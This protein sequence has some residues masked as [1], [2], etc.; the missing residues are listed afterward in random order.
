MKLGK[1]FRYEFRYQL[2]HAST[3][4]FLAVLLLLPVVL[5]KTSTPADGTYHNAPSSIAFFTVGAGVLWL[6]MAG[7][8][9]GDAAARDVQTRMHPLL[10]TAPVSKASYLG[11]RFLAALALNSLLLL[12]VQVGLL[13][14]FHTPGSR[15]GVLLGPFRPDAYLTAYAFLSLPLALAGTAVQFT[16]AA[17]TRRPITSYLGSVL[18]FITSHFIVMIMAHFVGWWGLTK[19]LDLAGFGSVLSSE[20]ETWTP[21]EQNTRLFVP[22]GL[23]LWNRLIWLGVALGLLAFTYFRFQVGHP[24]S[25]P[26]RRFWRRP[27]PQPP[28]QPVAAVRS[29]ATLV[30]EPSSFDF[31]THRHQAL[32]VAWSSFGTLARSRV[33]LT[34]VTLI[35]LGAALLG[36]EFMQQN[37]IP[38]LPTTQQVV[39]FLT[40]PLGDVKTPWIIMP[41]L[42]MYFAGELVW[43]EREAGLSEIVDAAPVPEW[44]LFTGKF[45]G[46]GLLVV[47]WMGILL[48]GGLLLQTILGYHR[49]EIGLY[50][51]AL[52]GLQLVEYLLFALLALA[53]HALVNQK[54]VGHLVL[55]LALGFMGFASRLG[56]PHHL[57]VFGAA[58][59][60]SYTDIRGYGASLGPWLWFKAYWAA[61]AL[62]LAV[63]ATLFWPRG[64]QPSLNL[65]AALAR[66]RFT[67]STAVAAAVAA[68][69]VLILGGFIFYN[70]NVLNRYTTAADR[71]RQRAEYERRYARYARM[72]QPALTSTRLQVALYPRQQAVTIRGTYQLVNRSAGPLD[73]IHLAPAQGVETS[74]VSFG[75]PATQV[76]AD[77]ELNHLIYKLSRPLQPGDSLQLTFRV[78]ARPRGFRHDG[79]NALV[80][81]SGTY[82][83]YQDAL[84]GIGY[85]TMRELR[86]AGPRRQYG[87]RPRPDIPSL[88]DV[89]A[90]QKSTRGD[91]M[92]F[93]AVVG[94]DPDQVAVAPG[95]LR[96]TWTAQGRRYFHYVTDAPIQNQAAF[97]SAPYAVRQTRWTYPA[98][99]QAVSISLY[100]FPGHAANVDRTLRSIRASLD[101]YTA[102]FGRYPYG[103]LTVVER[104]GNEGE[105]N[106]EASTIDYGEQFAL[107]RPDDGPR[108]FDLPYYVLAHE[109]AHQFGGAYASVEGVQVMSE[110]LAVYSGM[111]VLENAYGYGHL[112]RYLSFLRQSYEVP[113]SRAMAPLLRSD[114]AFLG[115][116]KGPLALYALG[117]YIGQD[118]VNVAIRQMIAR[119]E[120]EAA[121][122]A[123][124][125][126]LYRELRAATPDSLHCLLRDL[127]E[128][129]TYW[130]LKTE[131]ATTRQTAAGTWQVTLQVQARKVVV[132]ST[133][134]EQQRPMNDWV[135]VG[136]IAPRGKGEDYGQPLYRQQHRI[137]SGRQIIRV[138]VPRK[139]ARAGIDPY[140]LLI[141]LSLDDNVTA[142]KLEQ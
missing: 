86:D 95:R 47:V 93:E 43:R 121:P 62:L 128:T 67:R 105:L 73:S 77:K 9:S 79:V 64:K 35:A 38:L 51:Q 45:L 127:F 110:G 91:W 39:D 120:A 129:N 3:W 99:G 140:L 90:R 88:Y 72:P 137:R 33:G 113:R 87:L 30:S 108:G 50:V 107:M 102:Q 21:A 11:G 26:A 80:E 5:T 92:R 71:T 132:D 85:Q 23:L 78:Q 4:L 76:L 40:T 6:L 55:L 141:D 46:L 115:Y 74:V 75:R 42:L 96:R 122:L 41:L 1:I 103:H 22:T 52:F 7:A 94:T 83:M 82:L 27:K 34:L 111:Q 29:P 44:A 135:E 8:I 57:L 89:A 138:T 81:P 37:T 133:G 126:D 10:Y 36:S 130:K 116:R 20:L 61:W 54:Y 24:V 48:L 114:N 19:L 32:V 13:I 68:G 14:G 125:L 109:M 131:Q 65:R 70:T 66:R 18:L 60:W 142:V 53:V 134:T 101:Y 139:P 25:S 69:M 2:R 28:S 112:R 136:V 118:K 16:V 31:A 100:Y 119:H 59:E 17:L 104:A 117:R 84:P 15:E 58:P 124:T 98:A 56:I 123:T 49:F 63:A 106:A 12:A 97:F